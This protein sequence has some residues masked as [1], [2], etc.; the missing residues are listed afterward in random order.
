M[1][2]TLA[3]SGC[4]VRHHQLFPGFSRFFFL[5]RTLAALY[6]ILTIDDP[7]IRIRS[8]RQVKFN[9]VPFV[10]FFLLFIGFIFLPVK[11][12]QSPRKETLH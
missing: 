3:R 12:M 10:L 8:H 7:N 1:D 5:A 9:A 2:D 11:G 4:L 6:F